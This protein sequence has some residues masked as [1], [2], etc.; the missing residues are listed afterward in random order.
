[1]LAL[2]LALLRLVGGHT[3][4]SISPSA[5]G[6]RPSDSGFD[7]FFGPSKAE[8]SMGLAVKNNEA[9]QIVYAPG[10]FSAKQ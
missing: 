5:F 6:L 7:L 4:V 1:M 2:A 10:S 3:H 9:R 8:Q